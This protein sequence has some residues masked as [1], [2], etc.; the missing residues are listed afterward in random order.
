MKCRKNTRVEDDKK[1]MIVASFIN[2]YTNIYSCIICDE[3]DSKQ[4][5][6]N[7]LSTAAWSCC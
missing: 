7:K 1:I 5:L 4:K 3:N 6:Y 2:I